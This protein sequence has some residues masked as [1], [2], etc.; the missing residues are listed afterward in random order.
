M[1]FGRGLGETMIVVLVLSPANHLT[2]SLLGPDGLGSIALQITEDFV[3][4]SPIAQSA[5]ILLGLVLFLTT[6]G[7]NVL[8]RLVVERPEFWRVVVTQTLQ[9][10]RVSATERSRPSP[11]SAFNSRRTLVE[12]GGSAIA[13]V[14][15]VWFSFTVAGITGPLGFGVCSIAA[16]FFIYGVLCWLLH[17]VLAMKD[18]LA[19]FAIWTGA[20]IALVPLLAVILYVV[21]KGLPGGAAHFR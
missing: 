20:L 10:P 11:S 14:C 18:R 5:L 8:A 4:S 19:T 7:I 15:V 6:L 17:G 2:A 1:G 21:F 12:V 3:T 9:V 13:A 16:F